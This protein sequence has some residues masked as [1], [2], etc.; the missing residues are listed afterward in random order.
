MEPQSKEI[1]ISLGIVLIIIAVFC[2]II[3]WPKKEILISVPSSPVTSS[4]VP[5]TSLPVTISVLNG[6]GV[7][8]AAGKAKT[9]LEGLGYENVA[10]G[11]AASQDF[12][13][14][15]FEIKEKKKDYLELLIKDLAKEYTVASK[16]GI[17]EDD[18]DY[19]AVVTLG[20]E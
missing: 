6:S 16:S 8:G 14:T 13:E 2:A 9:T 17:L 10:V 18:N 1:L 11:N 7:A 4:P 5:V 3:F 15:E 19:D 12:A 20:K